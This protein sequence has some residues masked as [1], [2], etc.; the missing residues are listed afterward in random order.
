MYSVTVVEARSPSAP[1]PQIKVICCLGRLWKGI[2]SLPLLTSGGCQRP[3]AQ[4]HVVDPSAP[5]FS[6]V[7]ADSPWPLSC[8]DGYDSIL[9][10]GP[11]QIIQDN[12][13]FFS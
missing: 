7:F 5:I 1:D 4:G 2:R 9:A 8:K 10:G 11:T 13:K 12:L 3:L 6:S